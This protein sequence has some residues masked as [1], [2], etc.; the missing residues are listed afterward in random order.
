MC[1][2][3]HALCLLWV[4]AGAR[5]LH[6][7]PPL[8]L[9]GAWRGPG[10]SSYSVIPPS[11][12]TLIFSATTDG[13]NLHHLQPEDHLCHHLEPPATELLPHP[14][15][16]QGPQEGRGEMEAPTLFINLMSTGKLQAP[17]IQG[18]WGPLG[19]LWE[20]R[21]TLPYTFPVPPPQGRDP[22]FH[23]LATKREHKSPQLI[24]EV[25]VSRYQCVVTQ[26]KVI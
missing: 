8:L 25:P 16:M 17:G 11:L 14:H 23:P 12:S 6:G 5:S 15:Q 24:D 18:I 2:K 22:G 10:C 3:T 21:P 20:M 4:L 26:L 9:H 7:H 13:Q 1:K 19:T